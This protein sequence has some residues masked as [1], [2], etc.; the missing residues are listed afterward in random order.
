MEWEVSK[1][2]ARLHELLGPGSE[3]EDDDELE[4]AEEVNKQLLEAIQVA[5]TLSETLV[6]H[7]KGTVKPAEAATLEPAQAT[8]P[9]E[10]AQATSPVEPAQA[11]APVEP[12]QATSVEPAKAEEMPTG[13]T[14]ESE[15]EEWQQVGETKKRSKRRHRRTK[16]EEEKKT[17]LQRL[18]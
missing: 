9:V 11:T 15:E 5:K 12:A 14:E 13:D 16:K 4:R 8:S 18:E 17:S 6:Q 3:E 2:K 7:C 10:P 1:V